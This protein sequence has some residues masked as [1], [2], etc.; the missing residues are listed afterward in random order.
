[1][2]G[3]CL[4]L[5]I[6]KFILIDKYLG[7][8]N[9]QLE[10]GDCTIDVSCHILDT[11]KLPPVCFRR[12]NFSIKIRAWDCMDCIYTSISCF[13]GPRYDVLH[14]SESPFLPHISCV[15]AALHRI[16]S[17]SCVEVRAFPPLIQSELRGGW[18]G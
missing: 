8:P 18:R 16:G 15:T 13:F 12:R 14:Q 6:P 11:C 3:D 1:M 9:L 10:L 4:I 5:Y 2:A 17:G 7:I